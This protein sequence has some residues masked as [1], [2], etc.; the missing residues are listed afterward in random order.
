MLYNILKN[1]NTNTTNIIL[2]HQQY[3]KNNNKVLPEMCFNAIR[4]Y[5][6][7]KSLRNRDVTEFRV[8]TDA[9]HVREISADK[10]ETDTDEENDDGEYHQSQTWRR[11]PVN[12]TAKN[13]TAKTCRLVVHLV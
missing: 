5:R 7:D 13:V 12:V 2:V 3:N 1:S 8:M 11:H 10:T 6:V 9:R 4:L